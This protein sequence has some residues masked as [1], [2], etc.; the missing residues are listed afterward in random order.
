AEALRQVHEVAKLAAPGVGHERQGSARKSSRTHV[1]VSR[2]Q[3][4]IRVVAEMPGEPLHEGA[5]VVTGHAF[6]EGLRDV[7]RC[8]LEQV[9]FAKLRVL[10]GQSPHEINETAR[11]DTS[12]FYLGE[13]HSLGSV[14]DSGHEDPDWSAT[15]RITTVVP[16]RQAQG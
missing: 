3:Q 16:A 9:D 6:D 8:E 13:S 2:V 4:P 11:S 15:E 7:P 5:V 10:F 14:M 1:I 12:V